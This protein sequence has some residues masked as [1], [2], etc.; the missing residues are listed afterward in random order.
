MFCP[1]YNVSQIYAAFVTHVYKQKHKYANTLTIYEALLL[2]LR[3]ASKVSPFTF[4]VT[5]L[6]K[7]TTIII[8]VTT[9][10]G[11]SIYVNIYHVGGL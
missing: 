2:H 9:T 5:K 3:Y 11:D 4:N 10:P 1:Q 7:T 8:M 6:L